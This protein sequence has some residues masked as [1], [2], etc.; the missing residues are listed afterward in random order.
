MNRQSFIKRIVW[1]GIGLAILPSTSL[2]AANQKT[3]SITQLTGK[4]GLS[5]TGSPQALQVEVWTAYESMRKAALL[6]GISLRIVSGYRSYDRQLSIYNNKYNS[7]INQGSTPSQAIAEI[8]EYSTLPGTS[9]H[10]WGTDIDLI[11][12]NKPQPADP[13]L[14]EHYHGEGN[15]SELK[16]WMDKYAESFGFYEVYSANPDR[17]GFRYE[18]WHFSY[19]PTAVTMLEEFLCIDPQYFTSD[20]N[21]AGREHLSQ[22]FLEKYYNENI[23][24]INPMLFPYT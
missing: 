21:L 22:S 5:L 4:G 20:P 6:E 9:R 23:L 13:L 18:P 15:Y 11:D 10:H 12:A 3:Y 24:D 16:K 2:F 1:S 19:L 8:L 17:K 14:E 7:F